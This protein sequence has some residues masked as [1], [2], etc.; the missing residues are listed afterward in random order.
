MRN[1]WDFGL[2][3]LGRE[4]SKGVLRGEERFL[5]WFLTLGYL[6]RGMEKL[7]QVVR[8]LDSISMCR[9]WRYISNAR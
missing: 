2:E 5:A 9:R 4:M 8:G 6:R 3:V 1:G 7:K